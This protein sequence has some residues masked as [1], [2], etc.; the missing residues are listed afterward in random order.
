MPG[1]AMLVTLLYLWIFLELVISAQSRFLPNHSASFSGTFQ[2]ESRMSV[3]SCCVKMPPSRLIFTLCPEV[4]D[5][6]LGFPLHET[7]VHLARKGG[8][9][10]TSLCA[11]AL[12]EVG[13]AQAP[14]PVSVVSLDFPI[15]SLGCTWG[16]AD[17][18]MNVSGL[19][20]SLSEFSWD[21]ANVCSCFSCVCTCVCV[22]VYVHVCECVCVY[23]YM[24]VSVYMCVIVHISV[25]VY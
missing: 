15:F 13:R 25:S 14:T 21:G 10:R 19:P 23:M 8:V 2:L 17:R 20:L 6:Y 7:F 18:K 12:S 4:S 1:A 3:F 22:R 9:L 16:T 11:S 5:F 24:C